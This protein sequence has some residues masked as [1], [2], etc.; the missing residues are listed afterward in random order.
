MYALHSKLVCYEIGK[1]DLFKREDG[2]GKVETGEFD[3][4]QVQKF[5]NIILEL[6]QKC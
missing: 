5:I 6:S 2:L 1:V 3:L 4:M